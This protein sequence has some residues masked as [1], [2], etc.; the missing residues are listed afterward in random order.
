MIKKV[1]VII[2]T[3][4]SEK[5]IFDCL[6]SIFKY[7]DIG[8]SLEV[9]IVDN[10]SK[11]Q[12][13]VFFKVIQKYGDKII[14][15]KSAV[16]GGYGHGNNQGIMISSSPIVIV[17]NPD[18]RLILPVFSKIISKINSDQ[19]IGMMGVSFVDGSPKIYFKPDRIN[20]LK[21]LFPSF[22]I[23]FKLFNMNDMFLSGSF[24]IFVR[25]TFLDVGR[26]DENIFMYHEEADVSN[27]M[28]E[29]GKECYLFD[30]ISV[31]HL[32]HG[33]EV[34]LNLLKI[35]TESRNYYFKK[36]GGNLKGYYS[37]LIFC[38]K[39]KFVLAILINNKI[40]KKEF[41]AWIKMCQEEFAKIS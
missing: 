41:K 23:K 9:I 40:K 14:L 21:Y 17:M 10:C 2:V 6:D 16:N 15:V 5:L 4:N 20:M 3:Y 8:N 29:N 34:N 33:R 27:R 24:L 12:E 35:G 32:A 25:E 18:V 1:S 26:F 7:N 39:I 38:Y 31:L 36:F 30:D 37:M 22:F 19:N 13:N 28:I 11:D